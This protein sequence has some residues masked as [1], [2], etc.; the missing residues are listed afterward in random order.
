MAFEDWKKYG[1]AAGQS[2]AGR[3][4]ESWSVKRGHLV[5]SRGGQVESHI[6]AASVN[7]HLH[8]RA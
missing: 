5:R 3:P 1:K 6:D 4:P 8:G 7:V 2:E